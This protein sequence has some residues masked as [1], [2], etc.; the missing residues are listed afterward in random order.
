MSAN[1]IMLPSAPPPLLECR[2]K[3]IASWKAIRT[4]EWT[5]SWHTF[6]KLEE[7]KV[8]TGERIMNVH[9][10]DEAVADLSK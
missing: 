6:K 5:F 10:V 7:Y 8:E 2:E 9:L 1:A 3:P 4:R